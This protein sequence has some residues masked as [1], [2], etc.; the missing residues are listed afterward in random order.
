MRLSDEQKEAKKPDAQ[1]KDVVDYLN[2]ENDYLNKMMKHTKKFQKNLF[3]EITGRIKQDDE[4]VPYLKNGYTY[5]T[6]L[7][8]VLS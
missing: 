8:F 7:L 5:Y 1:T 6:R 2:A 4:S 3:K